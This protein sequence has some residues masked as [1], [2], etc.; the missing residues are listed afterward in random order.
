MLKIGDNMEKEYIVT[1]ACTGSIYESVLVHADN[2]D[3]AIDKALN[4]EFEDVVDND[5]EIDGY[6]EAVDIDEIKWYYDRTTY[7]K[8]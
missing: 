4:Y 7:C 2:E 8:N 6:E 5:F 3:E 1:I